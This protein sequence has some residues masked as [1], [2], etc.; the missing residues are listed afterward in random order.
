MIVLLLTVFIDLLGFGIVFPILPFYAKAFGASPFEITL[1]IASYSAMQII[2]APLWGRLSDIFGRKRILVTTLTGGA[3]AYFLFSL[4]PNLTA[5]LAARALSG[6]MAGNIAVAQAFMADI[7]SPAERAKGMGRIGAAFGLGL[8][9][10]PIIGGSLFDPSAGPS[11]FSAPCLAAALISAIAALLGSL[12]LNEPR[13]KKG[14]RHQK[15]KL[16]DVIKALG[17]NGIPAILVMNFLITLSFTAL[18]AI[19]PIWGAVQMNWGPKEVGYAFAW[20]GLLV[21]TMQGIALGK[22]TQIFGEEKVFMLGSICMFTGMIF[23]PFVRD[24]A[25]FALNAIFLCAGTSFCHPTIVALLSRKT[26]TAF[27]G[28]VLGGANSIGSIGRVLSPPIAGAVFQQLGHNWPIFISALILVPVVIFSTL[29]ALKN[30]KKGY[31]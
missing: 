28:S 26:S 17:R 8:V 30:M 25:S 15:N 31:S 12:I 19:F 4:A 13:T 22:L 9:A 5:L 16:R 2:S 10:G 1:L 18:M 20:I 3:I 14:T 23:V 11:G 27:Q 29:I 21:A 7:T 6:V 24:I